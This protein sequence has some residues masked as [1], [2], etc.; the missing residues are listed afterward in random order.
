[1]AVGSVRTYNLNRC[2]FLVNGVPVGGFSEDDAV[3]YSQDSE[4]YTKT[5][6]A[7]GEVT[8]SK[9]NSKAGTFTFNIMN[10][11]LSNDVFNTFLQLS[12]TVAVG[13]T[14]AVFIKDLASGDTI[15]APVCWI[16][17][18]PDMSF[19]REASNREWVV[20]A[21]NATTNFGGAAA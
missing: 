5:V 6:G 1:M 2:I 19:A 21:G 10:T 8:R 7:D 18:Q 16:E 4:I 11:S 3:S 13:D 12:Q 14:F 9:I 17:S 20:A 15:I